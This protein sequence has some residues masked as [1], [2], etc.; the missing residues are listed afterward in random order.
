MLR[1][2]PSTSGAALGSRPP[3]FNL[4]DVPSLDLGSQPQAWTTTTEIEYG[5]RHVGIPMH[6]LT[7]G[8]A[9]SEPQDPGNVVRVDQI[10]D[11]H[12]S[13]HK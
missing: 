8:I 4:S 1:Q 11:E 9:M 10:I 13:G 7:D 2:R 12:S 3:Q 5:A 6:V